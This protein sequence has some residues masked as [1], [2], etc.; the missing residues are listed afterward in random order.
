MSTRDLTAE[1]L[2]EYLDYNPDTGIFTWRKR[3][4]RCKAGTVAGNVM[5]V[6]YVC[7]Q[8]RGI[9]M[10][11][12]RLAWLYVHGV[13]PTHNI[14]HLNGAKADNRIA[15]LRDVPQSLNTQNSRDPRRSNPYLGVS[16]K[17]SKWRAQIYSEGRSVVLGHFST[18][19]AAHEAYVKA[20]RELHAGYIS[21]H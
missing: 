10:Y 1:L 9:A 3:S 7:I 20:K 2:R 11:A 13:H 5:P 19:E 14:D 16:K 4:G 15:N 21:N 8:V 12:H 6:G 17:R 18:P